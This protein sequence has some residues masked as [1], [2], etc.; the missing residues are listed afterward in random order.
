MASARVKNVSVDGTPLPMGIARPEQ[1]F[2]VSTEPV[3]VNKWNLAAAVPGAVTVEFKPAFGGPPAEVANLSFMVMLWKWH[4]HVLDQVFPRLEAHLDTRRFVSLDARRGTGNRNRAIGPFPSA[5]LRRLAS[6]CQHPT[7]KTFRA[8]VTRDGEQWI[9]RVPSLG[10]QTE[11][12]ERLLDVEQRLRETIAARLQ[13]EQRGISLELQ[14]SRGISRER[15]RRPAP[16]D[17]AIHPA[18]RT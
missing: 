18:V 1:G 7:V 2:G 4:D 11:K 5:Q 16:P 3:L 8:E 9:L 17:A 13:I 10:N 12:G 14:D 6:K 15:V